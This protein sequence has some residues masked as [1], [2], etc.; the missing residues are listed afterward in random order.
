MAQHRQPTK[1]KNGDPDTSHMSLP[2]LP[3]HG[4]QSGW[5][6]AEVVSRASLIHLPRCSFCLPI[7]WAEAFP[8][9]C[10]ERLCSSWLF[11]CHTLG[12][13]WLGN[14]PN[15]CPSSCCFF[16]FILF[17][18]FYLE[19]FHHFPLFSP[20]RLNFSRFQEESQAIIHPVYH[21]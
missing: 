3:H 12:F 17:Y 16:L 11:Q 19:G 9:C 1:P 8:E 6:V 14:S 7:S 15:L 4:K 13:L 21:V 5:L 18:F 2:P 10:A 20:Q